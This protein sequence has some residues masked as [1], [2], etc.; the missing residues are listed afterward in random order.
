MWGIELLGWVVGV[1]LV[2]ALGRLALAALAA[3]GDWLTRPRPAKPG[4][5][6][7]KWQNQPQP[8]CTKCGRRT[9]MCRCIVAGGV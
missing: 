1:W 6:P 3:F 4:T 7:P 8:Y 9:E 2:I 5:K